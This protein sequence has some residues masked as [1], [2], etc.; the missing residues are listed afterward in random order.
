[1]E[2]W[3]PLA[4]VVIL[5]LTITSFIFYFDSK[6][7]KSHNPLPIEELPEALED[8]E[9]NEQ[10]VL[11]VVSGTEYYPEDEGQFIIRLTDIRS[12]PLS[13]FCRGTILYP[14][15]TFYIINQ[16]MNPS[17]IDG[18]YYFNFSIPAVYGIYE[19]YTECYVNTT[20]GLALSTKS[21]SFHVNDLDSILVGVNE[22]LY[23]K[24][25]EIDT[26]LNILESTLIAEIDASET[27]ILT[28]I[29]TQFNN[30]YSLLSGLPSSF[31]SEFASQTEDWTSCIAMRITGVY[32]AGS[33]CQPL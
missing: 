22:T 3:K 21:S 23:E 33:T 2:I 17:P 12:R 9:Y 29:T 6:N 31:T 30:L 10:V 14:N 20:F 11:Q 5:F 19:E 1:M 24:I 27:S 18:N 25:D 7:S 26:E 32:P 15:K 28:E 16:T 8:A 13:G 4:I